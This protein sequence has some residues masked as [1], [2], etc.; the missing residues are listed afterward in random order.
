RWRGIKLG[1][2]CFGA[3]DDPF[4]PPFHISQQGWAIFL[5]V[6]QRTEFDDMRDGIEFNGVGFTAQAQGF[7]WNSAST[8]EHVEDTRGLAAVGIKDVFTRLLK[9]AVGYVPTAKLS[10]TFHVDITLFS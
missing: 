10:D 9:Y 2:L 3:F 7:E 5:W 4:S 8:C 6:D 1:Q